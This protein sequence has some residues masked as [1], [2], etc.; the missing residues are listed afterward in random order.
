MATLL[1]ISQLA[2]QNA[3]L[4]QEVEPKKTDE[5]PFIGTRIEEMPYIIFDSCANMQYAKEREKCSQNEMMKFVHS[6]LKYPEEAKKARIEGKVFIA[7]VVKADG[8]M[9]DFK[10]VKDIGGGCGEEALRVV[11]LIGEKYKWV[12]G[13]QRGRAVDIQYNFPV[14]FQLN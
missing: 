5:A 4:P 2:A 6:E 8:T 3:P 9:A 7:F 12:A 10:L 11:K 14:K 13:K 1:A